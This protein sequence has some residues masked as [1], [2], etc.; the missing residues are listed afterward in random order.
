MYTFLAEQIEMNPADFKEDSPGRLVSIPEAV[1][2]FIPAPLPQDLQLSS[3]T[4]DILGKADRAIGY[5]DAIGQSL[6][7]PSL[8]V[9]PFIRREAELSSRIEGTFATQKDLLLFEVSPSSGPVSPDVREVANYVDALEHGLLRLNEIPTSLRLIR[10]LHAKLMSGVRGD[11][12]RPGE[13][14]RIQN[15]IGQSNEPIE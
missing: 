8:L 10:E 15:F 9:K 14:R 6:P 4:I 11:A 2:A 13:F 3:E 7:N 12:Q 5:L 1:S